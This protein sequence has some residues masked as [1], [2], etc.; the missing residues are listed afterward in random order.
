M[1]FV[2]AKGD[3]VFYSYFQ[4]VYRVVGP[5]EKRDLVELEA[6]DKKAKDFISK[7]YGQMQ[8]FTGSVSEC[9]LYVTEMIRGAVR[10]QLQWEARVEKRNALRR[11]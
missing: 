8:S 11:G 4:G 10:K 9:K 3:L 1:S 2:P 5:R 6:Y 7:S